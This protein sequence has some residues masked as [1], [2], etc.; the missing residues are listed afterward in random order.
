MMN[1][2]KSILTYFD[3]YKSYIKRPLR[4]DDLNYIVASIE[5]N[6]FFSILKSQGIRVIQILFKYYID[7]EQYEYNNKIKEAVENHNKY[8]GTNY[9]LYT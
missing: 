6:D 8:F 2:E 3:R 7:T 9:K 4:V 1:T 5:K